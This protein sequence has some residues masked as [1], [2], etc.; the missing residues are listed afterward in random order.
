MK[1]FLFTMAL[2]FSAFMTANA[3]LA[4]EQPK[5]IFDNLY[6]GASVGAATP[7]QLS[8]ILPLNTFAEVRVG[9][10]ITATYAVEVNARVMF[11]SHASHDGRFSM[12]QWVRGT[13]L[14]VNGTVNFNNL[15]GRF[16]G[17]RDKF[18]VLGVVGLGWAHAFNNEFYGNDKNALSVKTAVEGRYNFND[19]LALTLQPSIVWGNHGTDG[20]KFN[21]NRAQLG[22]AVGVVYHFK[23]ANGTH[24]FKVHDV[25]ALNDEINTLRAQLAEKPTEVEKIVKETVKE[26][27][28]VEVIK[29]MPN[30]WTVSFEKAKA[31]LNDDAKAM[32]DAIPTDITVKIVGKASP[33][34]IKAFNQKL[35]QERADVVK[36]YLT[37]KG[38][39]VASAEGLGVPNN[40]SQRVAII[41]IVE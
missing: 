13:N 36:N 7:L 20:F 41:K 2:L 17:T 9:K 10:E 26:E 22:V 29:F 31:T 24:N 28:P 5:T 3:Q 27:V 23:N 32:L 1:K 39:K 37:D 4:I 8:E 12:H 16:D 34:G 14:G 40:A 19:A 30:E 25:G 18:E 35:S 15:F 33:E 6:V 11:G 38:M 21:S